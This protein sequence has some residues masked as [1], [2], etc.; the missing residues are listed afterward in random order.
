MRWYSSVPGGRGVG[1]IDWRPR[2]EYQHTGF[3]ASLTGSSHPAVPRTQDKVR[4]PAALRCKCHA[5]ETANFFRHVSDYRAAIQRAIAGQV[6]ELAF[7]SVFRDG[8]SCN[9][10]V[11]MRMTSMA[12]PIT[13]ACACRHSD[14]TGCYGAIAGTEM[15]GGRIRTPRH[16]GHALPP[17][18]GLSEM[19]EGH[20]A[21]TRSSDVPEA[22][23]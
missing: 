1:E 4:N 2:R 10:I 11:T 5:Q 12:L 6:T 14:H 3:S 19:G 20:S 22:G 17:A 7:S 9:S 13:S 16:L 18:W 23:L 15:R 21:N 8:L